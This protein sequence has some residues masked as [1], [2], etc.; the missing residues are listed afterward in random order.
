MASRTGLAG[1][2]RARIRLPDGTLGRATT[3]SGTGAIVGTPQVGVDEN[4][5]ATA[6]WAQAGRYERVMAAYHPH[7][8]PFGKPVEVGRSEAFLTARPAIAV[9]RFGDTAVAWNDGRHVAVRR[10]AANA[11]CA[12]A[13]HFACYRPA[14][15][16]RRGAGHAVTIGPLGSAYVAYVEVTRPAGEVRTRVRMVVVR[17]S[18]R[19]STDHAVSH[20]PDGNASQPALAVRPD[21]IADLAWR[22]SLPA[23]GAEDER[24]PILTAASNPS[25][26]V[27]KPQTLSTLPGD[28]P[29]IRVTRQREAIVSWNQIN[30]T[31]QNPDGEEVAYAVRPVDATAFGPAT[32][33][34]EPGMRAAGQSLA[35]DAA[36]NAIV[37][38]IAAPAIGPAPGGA[39][40]RS[41]LRP[42][43]AI[44]GPPVAIPGNATNGVRV[45]GAGTKISA[46]TGDE[47]GP[48]ITDW[49]P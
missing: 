14:V 15:L 12:P 39:L 5:N 21:G 6:V 48:A 1:S 37:A 22:S 2:I 23:T 18:G 7:G 45:F 44:F 49:K 10:R 33:I 35:I 25:A 24:A 3:I 11:R 26:V 30:S 42:A 27:T 34:S 4:G 31:P 20:T 32:T 16:L 13:R 41:H 40:G 46:D 47:R 43:G 29:F 17:R 36:G 38:Y 9:G 19:H 28:E 8:K